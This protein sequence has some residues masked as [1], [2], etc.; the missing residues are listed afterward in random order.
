MN[1]LLFITLPSLLLFS[2]IGFSQECTEGNCTDGQG[3][4]T[5]ADGDKYVGEWLNDKRTGQGTYTFASGNKYVGE[6]LNDKRHGYGLEIKTDGTEYLGEWENN[7]IIRQISIN[8]PR[9]ECFYGDCINGFGVYTWES[10]HR[11]EGDY[12][13]GKRS[14]QGVYLWPSGQKYLGR[15]QDGNYHGQGSLI[16]ANGSEDIGIWDNGLL[17]SPV[18][19]IDTH[20]YDD[21]SLITDTNVISNTLEANESQDVISRSSS[22]RG[23]SK[24]HLLDEF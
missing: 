10:G 1:K 4:M 13:N 11:Y 9:N 24:K 3:T 7:V 21:E 19:T 15:F 2:S 16:Y 23:I 12:L 22:F 5:Y 8:N 14:G 18:L 6:F 20:N 17:L